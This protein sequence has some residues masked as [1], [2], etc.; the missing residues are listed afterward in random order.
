[1]ACQLDVTLPLH[2]HQNFKKSSFLD[3]Q[4]VY[5]YGTVLKK[6]STATKQSAVNLHI[7]NN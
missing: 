7:Q 1:M 6:Q 2:F 3:Y 5:E 4:T